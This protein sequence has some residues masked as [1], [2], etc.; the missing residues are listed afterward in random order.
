MHKAQ[1]SVLTFIMNKMALFAPFYLTHVGLIASSSSLAVEG[2]NSLWST[3]YHSF[4]QPS[5]RRFYI[6]FEKKFCKFL[7]GSLGSLKCVPFLTKA[8]LCA[9]LFH[10][11]SNGSFWWICRYG[12]CIGNL[13]SYFA[14]SKTG[15]K[16]ETSHRP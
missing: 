4:A 3:T 13:L 16:G 12:G 8:F 9:F 7:G 14:K 1:P 10:P 11:T 6:I 15:S 2:Q 5:I